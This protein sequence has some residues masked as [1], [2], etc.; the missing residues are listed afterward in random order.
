AL[1]GHVM[2]RLL[3]ILPLFLVGFVALAQDPPREEKENPNVKIKRKVLDVDDPEPKTPAKTS[4]TA[5]P[6][7]LAQAARD[8]LNDTLKTLYTNNAP[9]HDSLK[10][11]GE[12]FFYVE[13]LDPSLNNPSRSYKSPLAFTPFDKAWKPSPGKETKALVE[14]YKPYEELAVERVKNFLTQ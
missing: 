10:V 11:R 12:G 4:R 8:A 6:A 1:G 7:D 13:P 2:A 9:P 14:D 5:P 3:L